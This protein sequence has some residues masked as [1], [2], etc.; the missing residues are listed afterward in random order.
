MATHEDAVINP[1]C[2]FQAI[3]ENISD[4]TS[5]SIDPLWLATHLLSYNVITLQQK[6][7]ATDGSLQA[8]VKLDKILTLVLRAVQRNGHVY[9]ILLNILSKEAQVYKWLIDKIKNSYKRLYS[10]CSTGVYQ[11]FSQYDNIPISSVGYSD[12]IN[13]RPEFIGSSQHPYIP[14]GLIHTAQYDQPIC[15]YS[16]H[17]PM[18]DSQHVRPINTMPGHSYSWMPG[19]GNTPRYNQP[20]CTST[21]T[22][23]DNSRPIKTIPALFG[24]NPPSCSYMPRLNT[25]QYNQPTSTYTVHGLISNSQY[26][27]PTPPHFGNNQNLCSWMPGLTTPRYNQ[28]PNI[29]GSMCVNDYQHSRSINTIHVPGLFNQSPYSWIPGHP[30]SGWYNQPTYIPG[31]IDN[32]HSNQDSLQSTSGL[33][34]SQDVTGT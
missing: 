4:F 10:Q 23:H 12:P 29:Y 28:L 3:Q 19:L 21:H 30:G 17:E 32:V 26:S 2:A 31:P 18:N 8:S 27:Q 16:V 14:H 6:D 9:T 34:Y 15:I 22:V 7:D 25:P 24:N 5:A 13:T 1:D 11:P 33:S 20:T